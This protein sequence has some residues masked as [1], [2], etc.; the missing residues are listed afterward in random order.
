MTQN[1]ID[2]VAGEADAEPARYLVIPAE[3]RYDDTLTRGE[4][5]LFGELEGLARA[6]GYCWASNEYLA[7]VCNANPKTMSRWLV[8]LH[9]CGYVR[10]EIDKRS[11][12]RRKIHVLIRRTKSLGL[13]A[14]DGEVSTKGG[15]VSTK[16][17]GLLNS[18]VNNKEKSIESKSQF[19]KPT[20]TELRDYADSIGFKN[21][22]PEEFIAH[23]ESNGWHVGKVKMKSWKYTVVTWKK[24]AA[25]DSRGRRVPVKPIN[26]RNRRIN[27]LNERK[28]Q[29]MRMDQTLRVRQELEQIRAELLDL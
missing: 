9:E 18:K 21:F 20:P 13:S 24:N 8:H 4:K 27:K 16:G 15:E 19:R 23:Y 10:V 12:N 28:A 14:K 1:E 6:K 7:R 26:E 2:F 5:W 22:D 3:V 17:G 11:G 25:K 29:L